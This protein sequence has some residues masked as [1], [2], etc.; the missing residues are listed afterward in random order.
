MPDTL[1]TDRVSGLAGGIQVGVPLP[2]M[3]GLALVATVYGLILGRPEIRRRADGRREA[4]RQLRQ[5]ERDLIVA[6][7]AQRRAQNQI[8]EL[9]DKIGE[10]EVQIAPLE[11]TRQRLEEAILTQQYEFAGLQGAYDRTVAKL[12]NARSATQQEPRRTD[13]EQ[14]PE[15]DRDEDQVP[16][17]AS[18]KY[19]LPADN[20]DADTLA[21]GGP[22]RRLVRVRCFLAPSKSEDSRLRPN[23]EMQLQPGPG[24]PDQA[25]QRRWIVE[26]T[27]VTLPTN[28]GPCIVDPTAERAALHP[29]LRDVGPR[30]ARFG[31]QIKDAFD[32]YAADAM[33]NPA[34]DNITD[35]WVVQDPGGVNAVAQTSGNLQK[36]LHRFFLGAPANSVCH[37]L[38]APPPI[39]NAAG[40]IVGALPLPVDGPMTMAKMFVQLVGI[41]IGVATGMPVLQIACTKSLCHDMLQ[42][43]VAKGIQEIGHNL[44]EVRT[45]PKPPASI[46][47]NPGPPLQSAV[48][49]PRLI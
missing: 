32:E 24:Q 45:Q 28:S 34:F 39:T 18:I 40:G 37:A 44:T 47:N 14:G 26:R 9:Q 43:A 19:Y 36:G 22:G 8:G 7:E 49:K 46:G 4:E 1:P 11:Q 27:I 20:G 12:R 30:Q 17:E 15:Q 35:W 6:Q 33:V 42:E 5:A 25:Q 48:N 16:D 13:E 21:A 38:G 10:L 41:V 3:G 2:A 31:D 23:T 29:V